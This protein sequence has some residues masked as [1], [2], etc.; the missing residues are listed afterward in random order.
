MDRF[1]GHMAQT[2]RRIAYPRGGS[3]RLLVMVGVAL[4]VALAGLVALPS[5]ASAATLTVSS[6]VDVA[7]T[8]GA[9]GNGSTMPVGTSLRE[10]VCVANNVGAT[11]STITVQAGTY[12]LT[13]G[14]LQMGKV[15]GSNITLN[16]AGAGSTTIQGNGTFRIFNLDPNLVGRVTSSISGVTI[17]GGFDS[18]FGAGGIIAG[19]TAQPTGAPLDALTVSNATI[20]NNRASGGSNTGG[21]IAFSGGSLTITNS[22]IS[23]NS[24]NGAQ[25]SG[26]WYRAEGTGPGEGLTISG[27]TFSGNTVNTSTVKVGGALAVEITRGSPAI[28][29]VSNSRFTGNT[30]AGSGAGTP[31]GGAIWAPSGVLNVTGSTFTGNSV[32]GGTSPAGGAID[33]SGATVTMHYNRFTGNTAPS[34]QAMAVTAGTVDAT[35]NWWGCN[36]GPGT[37]GCDSVAGSATVSPRL[38]LT[39]TASPATLVGPNA[40]TTITATLTQD[41]SGAAI[42]TTNL[43][44]FASLPIGWSDPLPSGA[45]LGSASSNLT[46]GSTSTSYN[47]QNSSGPGHVLATLDN[48]PATATLTVNRAPL[49]TSATAA[50]F[51]VGTASSFTV[52]TSGYPAPAITRTGTLPA[53]L[54]LVDNGNGTATL[55]GTP[56]AGGSY[57]L[58]LTANNGVNPNA[59]QTLTVNVTQ[60]PT[61][62]SASTATFPIGTAGS[63]AITTTPTAYPTPA[64]TMTGTVPPGLTFTANS[65]GTAT[66]SGTPTAA[67]SYSLGLTANNGVNPNG[68]QTL[69]VT[70]TQAPTFTSASTATFTV[71]TASSFTVTTSGYPA[72]AITRTG[73][74]PAG[75][76]LVDNGNGTATLAGTPTAGGGYLLSLTANNGVNPNATQTL[77]VNVTQAPTVTTNPVNQSVTAGASVTFSAAAA[78]F[79]TPTVQWQRAVAGGSFSAI[80]GAT[81]ASYSF[82]TVAGDNGTQYRAVFTNAVNSATST[83]A[84]LTVSP[85]PMPQPQ[86]HAPGSPAGVAPNPLPG[87]HVAGPLAGAT[88]VPQPV[89]H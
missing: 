80:P 18:T 86:L 22:T 2:F 43:G 61:F 56:T 30:V 71:G 67:G 27:T 87:S 47:S 17:T 88:P 76:T 70:V 42:A 15:S 89:Q 12:L 23:N 33:V 82:T 55:A 66:L 32:A 65:N 41:S 49:I 44:A 31:I 36:T 11:S 75:L 79:P 58:S 9:C 40:T 4:G 83:A 59:T 72:P 24:T 29:N 13:N 34:G 8:Y 54:T 78:G 38:V 57:S 68:T 74:L 50:T 84:T 26:V 81:G 48:G 28:F 37:T 64:I 73:T 69:T 35:D 52:T 63:F 21:G 62:T 1:V 19:S 77:T 85:P 16:G 7:T 46:S 6:T 20:T 5:V 39:A 51:T 3:G 25:G 45:T 14:E 53:G 60:A 10:A